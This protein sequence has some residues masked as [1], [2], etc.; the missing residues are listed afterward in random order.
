MTTIEALLV[1]HL[2][3]DPDVYELVG[4]R[5]FAARK[6]LKQP[7]PLVVY[8]RI[9]TSH[10]MS[11]DGRGLVGPRFEFACWGEN[12]AQARQLRR[13]VAAAFDVAT[14][15]EFRSFVENEMELTFSDAALPMGV[16]DV[17]VWYD[18]DLELAT[19]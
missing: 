17:R 1:Q 6:P 13:A 7:H 10:T 11:H 16:V 12:D 19:S 8:R 15:A 2:T 9:S 14:T 4:E 18:P 5:I 3:E